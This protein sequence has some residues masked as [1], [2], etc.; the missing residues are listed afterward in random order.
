MTKS[1]PPTAMPGAFHFSYL[2]QSSVPK[3]SGTKS[4]VFQPPHTPSASASSSLYLTRSA[5]GSAMSTDYHHV[6]NAGRKRA[7]VD[8]D[9]SAQLAS[10]DEDLMYPASPMP[11]VNTRYIIKGGMDTPTLAAARMHESTSEYSDVGYRRELS[12]TNSGLLGEETGGYQSFLPLDLDRE[13]DGRA[14]RSSPRSISTREGWSKTA[15]EV[16]GGVV[17]KVWEFCKTSAFKGF[18]AGEGNGYTVKNAPDESYFSLD[19]NEK[20]W[21]R[22][23]ITTTWGDDCESTPLPGRFPEEDFIP[24]Y[25]ANPTPDATPP[26]A[27][28]RRQVRDNTDELAR[29]WVFVPPS[30][31]RPS[32]PSSPQPRAPPRYSMQTTSSTSRRSV[33][34]PSRASTVTPRRP[35]LQRVSHAGSPALQ[36]HNGASYASPRSP[37]GSKI[38]LRANASPM[39]STKADDTKVDS[40]AARE[41]AKW[42]ALKK[43]EEREAD[44][45]IRR[46]DAQLKAMIREGKE[47]LGTKVE[48]EMDEEL[49]FGYK[50]SAG[51]RRFAV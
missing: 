1:S 41:A 35:M 21:A 30:D 48:V 29:N 39:R 19:I 5:T 44:V 25:M 8:N 12:G 4:H 38:P 20:S 50:P 31:T 45:T 11:F 24:N 10:R 26:R 28:K 46:L 2:D 33:A 6:S 14:R 42:A 34:R 43:K 23:Q 32:T 37:G 40:P 13:P 3:P 22:E 27:G 15:L 47:A 7:R 51:G 49:D 17:G 36:N 18:H 9:S 16:V